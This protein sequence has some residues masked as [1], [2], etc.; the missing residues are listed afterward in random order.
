MIDDLNRDE[1]IARLD[2]EPD[3]GCLRWKKTGLAAGSNDK[4]YTRISFNNRSYKAHRIIWLIAYGR[5]PNG[6][7]DH[8]N[9]RRSDNRISNLRE[10][11]QQENQQ[12]KLTATRR[13]KTSGLLGAH[14][15]KGSGR[16]Y[17]TISVDNRK[18]HIGSYKTPELA[19]AAYVERKRLLHAA[20]TL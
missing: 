8:I 17:A 7:I 15:H 1:V 19:H 16:W 10:V 6:Q 9:G 13:N 4:G 12:N 11:T 3:T 14:F 5:W 18:I 2:Y 20:S